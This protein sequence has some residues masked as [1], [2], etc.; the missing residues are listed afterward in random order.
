MFHIRSA[1]DCCSH[2]CFHRWQSNTL[3]S[4]NIV[5]VPDLSC[6][7][8]HIG[9]VFLKII[10]CGNHSTIVYYFC[11][12]VTSLRLRFLFVDFQDGGGAEFGILNRAKHFVG[13]P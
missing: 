3:L 6:K 4:L 10:C 7:F 2:N 8:N 12:S 9:I 11:L 1:D 13:L 5:K